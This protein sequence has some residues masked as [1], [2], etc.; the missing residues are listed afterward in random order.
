MAYVYI[1]FT[2]EDR[3]ADDFGVSKKAKEYQQS[4]HYKGYE[5][6]VNSPLLIDKN[7]CIIVKFF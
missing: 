6:I 7:E 5:V 3:N 2:I 4:H 1:A